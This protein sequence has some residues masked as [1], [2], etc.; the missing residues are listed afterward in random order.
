MLHKCSVVRQDRSGLL[1]RYATLDQRR[2]KLT[3]GIGAKSGW[4]DIARGLGR[5]RERLG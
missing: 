5:S 3:K 1:F 4:P 2:V